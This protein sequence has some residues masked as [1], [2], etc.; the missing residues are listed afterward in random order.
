MSDAG[1]QLL[2][3]FDGLC[4]LCDF[5]VNFIIDRDPGGRFVFAPLQSPTGQSLITRF[6]LSGT[7]VNSIILVDGDRYYLRSTAALKI[8][9][10]LS[11]LWPLCYAFIVV[12][13]PLRDSIYRWV[14]RNRYRWFGLRDSCRLPTLRVTER[15]VDGEGVAAVH[16]AEPSATPDGSQPLLHLDVF[17]SERQRILLLIAFLLVVM[18]GFAA[19]TFVPSLRVEHEVTRSAQRAAAPWVFALL[20]GIAGYEAVVLYLLGR[21]HRRGGQ[22][23]ELFR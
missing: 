19:V 15:F 20:A 5:S 3:L 8:A 9:R 16:H 11:G 17:D 2:V 6:N 18:V 12:P 13:R 22:P 23:P 21:F 4:N 1:Q 14:A 10:L 7:D